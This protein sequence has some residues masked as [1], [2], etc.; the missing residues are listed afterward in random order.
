MFDWIETE[1]E[2]PLNDRDIDIWMEVDGSTTKHTIVFASTVLQF[3][4][5]IKLF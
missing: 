4:F 5:P 1:E 3:G 2:I